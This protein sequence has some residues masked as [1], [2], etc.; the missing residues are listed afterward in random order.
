VNALDILSRCQTLGITLTPGDA[1]KLRVSPRRMLSDE[2]RE[3]LKRHKPAL[4]QLVS[5]PP[6]DFL[7]EA[8]CPLC[9]SQ[10]RWTWLDGRE[11]CRPCLILDLAPMALTSIWTVEGKMQDVS[12]GKHDSDPK[13]GRTGA[14][15][16]P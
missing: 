10:E 1:G 5:A 13:P 9:G 6:A 14:H 11:F 16:H 8:P 2:L 15:R 4:L 3:Q 12:R 7:S